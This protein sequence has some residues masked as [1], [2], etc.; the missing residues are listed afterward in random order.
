LIDHVQDAARILNFET[1]KLSKSE[2]ADIRGGNAQE[3][4]TS[5]PQ[6]FTVGRKWTRGSSKPTDYDKI[7]DKPVANSLS[8]VATDKNKSNNEQTSSKATESNSEINERVIEEMELTPKPSDSDYDHDRRKGSVKTVKEL[9]KRR[10]AARDVSPDHQQV[11]SGNHPNSH[12]NQLQRQLGG[13]PQPQDHSGSQ[14]GTIRPIHNPGQRDGHKDE[15]IGQDG[16]L[17]QK[18]QNLRN[19]DVKA[20]GYVLLGDGKHEQNEHDD[21]GNAHGAVSSEDEKGEHKNDTSRLD[22]DENRDN[23]TKAEAHP[24][25]VPPSSHNTHRLKAGP[26]Q[27][28][29]FAGVILLFIGMMCG[30]ACAVNSWSDSKL[31]RTSSRQQLFTSTP[32]PYVNNF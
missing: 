20:I 1:E 22:H 2:Q 30:C 16:R 11:A 21:S 5:N 7:D 17:N 23:T 25:E 27:I 12:R 19:L 10:Q 6:V 8:I 31:R 29:V 14:G 18:D 4:E 26:T 15:T 24:N 13:F 32:T 9:R 28:L 3:Q